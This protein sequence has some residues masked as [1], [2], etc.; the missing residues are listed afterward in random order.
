MYFC[1]KN[2]V[3]EL[4]VE[5]IDTMEYHNIKECEARRTGMLKE[6]VAVREDEAE[7]PGMTAE[8]ITDIMNYICT[9]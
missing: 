8:E 2:S 1:G 5:D 4:M 7:V 3:D 9:A 6:L